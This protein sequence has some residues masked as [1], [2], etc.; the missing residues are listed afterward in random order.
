[1]YESSETPEKLESVKEIRES[2][3]EKVKNGEDLQEVVGNTA[4]KLIEKVQDG[5]EGGVSAVENLRD[6]AK[7]LWTE[8]LR[9][10]PPE[11]RDIPWL[12]ECFEKACEVLD[13]LKVWI[14][15]NPEACEAAAKVIL[16]L[17][18]GFEDPASFAKYIQENPGAIEE[19]FNSLAPLLN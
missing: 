11:I 9:I 2:V 17:L 19:I 8:S 16:F 4:E 6:S 15:Q 5:L 18:V 1:M 7:E 13:N 14:E 3:L 10:L 12:T